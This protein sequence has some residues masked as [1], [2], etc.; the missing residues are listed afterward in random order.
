MNPKLLRKAKELTY[1]LYDP[2]WEPRCQHFSFIFLK[3]RIITIG[4]NSLK[5]DP[6]N[7]LN[8]KFGAGTCSE[9]DAIKKF[10]NKTNISYNKVVIINT[11]LNRKKEISIA[12]PCPGCSNLL[13]HINPRAVFYTN[14]IGE[15]EQYHI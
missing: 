8:P 6:T 15:F 13:R 9:W 1:A 5:T 11:R 2:E 3:G 14:N 10:K 12:R 7:L 4:K